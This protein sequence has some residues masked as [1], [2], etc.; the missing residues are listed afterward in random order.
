MPWRRLTEPCSRS[1]FSHLGERSRFLDGVIHSIEGLPHIDA[2]QSEHL[3]HCLSLKKTDVRI[4][5]ELV[6]VSSR[7][8]TGFRDLVSA[9][10][11]LGQDS[12]VFPLTL[13]RIPTLWD[14]VE[15]F[16]E[17]RGAQ[18]SPPVLPWIE[19][20]KMVVE[21]FGLKRALSAITQYLHD[22][23]KVCQT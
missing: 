9:V 15:K 13:R 16:V 11:R 23:S 4:H 21:R 2:V 18:L 6:C 3:K 8:N 14:D 7:L 20:E 10:R 12:A 5:P 19:Y 1:C 22:T 17:T